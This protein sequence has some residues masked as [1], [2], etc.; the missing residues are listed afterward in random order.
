MVWVYQR[1]VSERVSGSNLAA[2]APCFTKCSC[3]FSVRTINDSRGLNSWWVYQ[4][5]VPER[6]A[7]RISQ[8]LHLFHDMHLAASLKSTTNDPRGGYISA[9]CARKVSGSNLEAISRCTWQLLWKGQRSSWSSG[10]VVGTCVLKCPK[11]LAV[12]ISQ[13]LHL[14]ARAASRKGQRSSWSSGLAVC[15]CVLCRKGQRFESRSHCTSLHERHEQFQQGQHLWSCGLGISTCMLYSKG[16]GFGSRS[17]ACNFVP[18]CDVFCGLNQS[19][20]PIL[21]MQTKQI[22]ITFYRL[23]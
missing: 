12:R 16:H 1:V 23:S 14:V 3:S 19:L 8:P 17:N 13:L 6:S 5:V 9:C 7:V 11:G 21:V 20:K 4:R 18:V 2:T 10:L 22:Y 15:T